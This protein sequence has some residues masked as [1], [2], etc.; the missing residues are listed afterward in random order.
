M[1]RQNLDGVEFRDRN[2]QPFDWENKEL[3]E[4]LPEVEEHIYPDILAEIPGLVLESDFADE[5]DAVTTP[6]PPTLAKRAAAALSN[7]GLTKRIGVDEQFTGVDGPIT[8]VDNNTCFRTVPTTT[9]VE[10]NIKRITPQN[11][12]CRRV[13]VE[14]IDSDDEDDDKT[15]ESSHAPPI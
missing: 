9:Q 15:N 7:T 1:R 8:G 2:N 11:H 6:A 10:P 3:A 14:D 13:E 4:T 12:V 5:G